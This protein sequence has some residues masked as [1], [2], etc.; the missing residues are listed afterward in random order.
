MATT[1]QTVENNNTQMLDVVGR[2]QIVTDLDTI[3]QLENTVSATEGVA[4][5]KS[6]T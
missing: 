4:Q 1:E 6:V 3:K 5:Q 2:T